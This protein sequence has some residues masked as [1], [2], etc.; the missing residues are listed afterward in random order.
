MLRTLA[1][2]GLAGLVIAVDWLRFEDPKSSGE[3]PFLLVALAIAPALVRP[4]WPRVVAV[5]IS[6]LLAAWV[7]FSV[8]PADLWPGGDGYFGPLGRHFGGG[9]VD[10]YDFQ[11]PIDPARQPHMHEVILAAIFGFVLATALAIAARRVL[12]AVVFFLIGAGWP[13]TLLAGG[14]E[15]GRGIFILAVALVLLA[16]ITGRPNR[17]TLVAGAA[18]LV[19]AFALSSSAAVAKDAFL[20]WQHWDF[21]TRP[22][23]PVSVRY[24]WDGRYNGVRF[25]KKQT[26]VLLIRA[27]RTPQYWRATVLDQFDGTRWRE[28]LWQE[29]ALESHELT[30]EGARDRDNW[31]EQDVTV[32]ALRD[33]HLI[34]ASI[35]LGFNTSQPLRYAGQNVVRVV[36]GLHRDQ[37][38][39]ATSYS[40]H[41]T[42]AQLVGSSPGYPAALT[43]PGRELDVG[44]VTVPPFGVP[45]RDARVLELLQGRLE[46]YAEVFKRA[47]GVAGQTQSP[48][49][50]AVALERWFRATGGFTYSEQ[51]GSTP[52]LPPL[53]GF[54]LDTRTGY[55]QHFAGSMALM[56]RLLGIPARVAAGFVPGHYR[57]GVWRVTDHD[58]HAWVEV[59]FRGYGWLPFD[60]TPGRG[61]LSGSYSSTSSGF[62][63]IAAARLLA[64][65]VKGGEVFGQG[66]GSGI[67]THDPQRRNPRSAADLPVR[68]LAP[69]PPP[70]ESRTPSLLFFLFLL[71]AGVAAGIVL[72]KLGRRKSRYLTRDPRRIA[73]ACARELGEY[74]QDQRVP[75]PESA[76]FHELGTQV[77]ERLGVD[78]TEFSDAVTTARYGP[79]E[80][81]MSA[82]RR[83]RSELRE[84]KRKL[85]R[86][87]FILDRA[88]GLVSVRSL[89]LG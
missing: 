3:R 25:P 10:F 68:G 2:S 34:G 76:T 5:A 12:L 17:T 60:P 51:P 15:V 46:P 83:A 33:D 18:V 85:R 81:A 52:G 42:P 71:C 84:L 24:V 86:S 1:L 55:C 70:E 11:L 38:Y 66:S 88:R 45:G 59:W 50:V 65:I 47:N 26:T 78:S 4:L 36:D 37:H 39:T 77:W 80:E 58:A 31:I 27:P 69:P 53:V 56:L 41:P 29:T 8:S 19:G 57:E 75:A 89:G 74:L 61:R 14:D 32:A 73:T 20:D 9:F 63:P 40:A 28:H 62:N 82:A 22:Q 79:P 72:L 16:G 48:Y 21:Y 6:L 44:G 30:P 87:V 13:A 7:A 35:P 54:L 49:A 67:L 64:G 23:K 43:Q